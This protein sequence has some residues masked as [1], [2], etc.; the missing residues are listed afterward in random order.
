MAAEPR[1]IA[2]HQGRDVF[3]ATLTSD[4]GVRI[5]VMNYGAVVRDWQVPVAGGM[6]SVVL[7]FDH[8]EDYPKYGRYF[9][10]IIGRV[11]NRISGACFTLN[12]KEYH[13]Q[14]NEGSNQLH[15]GEGGLSHQV[16]DMEVLSEDAVRLS[17]I[18]PDGEMGYPGK[19][20]VSVTYRLKGKALEI[21]F[22]A[23]PDAPTPVN[24]VQ[25]NYFNLMGEGDIRNH[26]L[27]LAANA[28]TVRD[29]DLIPTGRIEP[30]AGTHFDFRKA[31][32]LCDAQGEP[33]AY[34][35]NL[36]LDTGRDLSTPAAVLKAPD[37]SLTLTLKTDQPGLQLYTGSKINLPVP[38]L[39]GRHYP[40]FA[41]LCLEDQHFP[42]AIN[43][44]HFPSCVVTPDRPYKHWCE[45]EIG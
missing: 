25:H 27:W 36:V 7:G 40:R 20:D 8:F 13:L 35:N 33:I 16:W 23:I 15:G 12:G 3:E 39:G 41:G 26:T 31:R 29:I 11:A 42:D 45:I 1:K 5:F 4:T 2:V 32:P 17:R 34:D 6:R 10:A 18:S 38:G 30:V 9:G 24:L 22:S 21:D 28:Y 44:P 14:P 19:L 37:G 43:Y